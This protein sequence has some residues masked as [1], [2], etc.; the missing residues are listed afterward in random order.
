MRKDLALACFHTSQLVQDSSWNQSKLTSFWINSCCCRCGWW[1]LKQSFR[2]C[3][4]TLIRSNQSSWS[5]LWHWGVDEIF[6]TNVAIGR[7]GDLNPL[8]ARPNFASAASFKA[9][10]S[11]DD[12][13]S[14]QLNA[15]VPCCLLCMLSV[16]DPDMPWPVRC[17]LQQALQSCKTFQNTSSIVKGQNP[18]KVP[19]LYSMPTQLPWL[20][21]S[22]LHSPRDVTPELTVKY[23]STALV[24][25]TFQY[26]IKCMVSFG[27]LFQRSVVKN[28][29][30]QTVNILRATMDCCHRS[31]HHDTPDLC[32]H[33]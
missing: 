25:N 17:N 14:S 20:A 15:V 26:N 23:L 13:P 19:S 22:C 6:Q 2:S 7:F 9:K 18:F 3:R 21:H 16:F 12:R 5:S 11:K 27:E 31:S 8:W 29:Q 10:Q 33:R 1:S 24:S 28:K 4:L 32:H 30:I